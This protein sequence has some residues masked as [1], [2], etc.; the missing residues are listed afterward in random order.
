MAYV[1]VH[2]SAAFIRIGDAYLAVKLKDACKRQRSLGDVSSANF[3]LLS[4]MSLL[5]SGV[6]GTASRSDSYLTVLSEL[7]L[8]AGMAST[9]ML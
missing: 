3:T 4:Q 1:I 7:C 6:A 5:P 2:C 8:A 9:S